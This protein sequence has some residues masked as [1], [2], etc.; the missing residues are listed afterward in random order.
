MSAVASWAGTAESGSL[1]ALHA[2]R[3]AYRC[4]GRSLCIVLLTPIAAYFVLRDSQARRAS[5][6]YLRRLNAW[7]GGGGGFEREPALFDSLL[8]FREFA[9]NIFDRLCVFVGGADRIEIR[10]VGSEHLFHLAQQRR[11]AILLGAHVGS[12]DMLRVLSERQKLTVNVL[13][14]TRHAARIT[15]FFE[16]MHPGARLRVIELD[17]GSNR[18]AFEIKACIDRGEFVGILGDRVG[19]DGRDRVAS[20]RFLGRPASFPLGPFL[21]A[22]LLGCPI[23]LSLCVRTGDARYETVVKVLSS[24]EVVPR[25]EREKRARELLEIYVRN[26]EEACRR[27][28]RQWF[29]FY[30]FWG[31]R[32]ELG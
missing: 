4:F 8:H 10:D 16:R 13:M 32:G 27:A 23:L 29:N 28:P 2:I 31:A 18:A 19:P 26:L 24:G 15:A 30:D 5:R 21:L 17:P 14:F 1:G 7:L 11:G 22:G 25:D 3:W 12:F 20:V 9:I 6:Q